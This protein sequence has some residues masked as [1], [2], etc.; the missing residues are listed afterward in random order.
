MLSGL[1]GLFHDIGKIN[2]T[3]IFGTQDLG[4][5]FHGAYGSTLLSQ[6]GSDELFEMI[7]S[8]QNYLD[9]LHTI[10]DHMCSYH[11][12]DFKNEWNIQRCESSQLSYSTNPQLK[13]LSHNLSYGDIFGKISDFSD[14]TEFIHSRAE[15][16]MIT[17]EPFNCEKFMKKNNATIPIFFVRGSSGS[18]KSTFIK[19][20]LIPYLL[21]FFDESRI[22]VISR[23]EVMCAL[24]ASFSDIVL[25]SARPTGD[26]Y[27]SLYKT[28]KSKKLGKNVNEE[29]KSRISNAISENRIAIIDSCILYYTGISEIMPEN[30]KNTYKIAIDCN[31][32]IPYSI[33]DAK[34]NG[35]KSIEELKYLYEFRNP[36]TW[37]DNIKFTILDSM[38]THSTQKN[39]TFMPHIVFSHGY[40]AQHECGFET[41][42]Q[43]LKT[44]MEYFV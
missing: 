22:E 32:S 34:K 1:T 38:Y 33:I 26:T 30:I 36:V 18:G 5:P 15:Y 24:A 43:V 28:Y 19:D 27:A 2:T 25:D 29:M 17:S 44:V 23:D 9:M 3:T 37:I 11:V 20:N 21:R 8:K 6:Y 41:L 39:T 12:T 14:Y 16:D 13:E 31:R 4:Y 42:Q 35:F 7:G 10:K 40:N